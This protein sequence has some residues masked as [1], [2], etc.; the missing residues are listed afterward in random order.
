MATELAKAYVQIVP[1]AEGISGSIS[2]VLSGEATTAGAGAGQSIA[3]S[4]ASTL[5]PALTA[6]GIGAI[7][8]GTIDTVA[9]AINEVASAGDEI[10]K[11]SQKLGVNAEQYQALS[12]AAEHCGFSTSTYST[13]VK[14]LQQSGYEG[15]LVDYLDGLMAIE[16]PTERAAQAQEVLGEKTAN[17]MAAFLNGS[18][19]ISDYGSR[20][21]ELGGMMSNESVAASAAF[22][23]A[24]TDL[25]TAMKG[26]AVDVVGTFLPSC[27]EV[28]NGLAAVFAGDTGGAAMVKQG[29]DDMI[30]NIKASAPQMI[31]SA[32]TLV[33]SLLDCF[34]DNLPE[35]IEMGVTIVLKLA[36]GL[37]KAIPQLVSQLPQICTAIVNGIKN[38]LPEMAEVGGN[39]LSG[40]WNGI[41]DKIGW[42]KDKIFGLG[43]QIISAIK[44]VFGIASPSKVMRDQVGKFIAEGVG[45]GITENTDYVDDAMTDLLGA[46]EGTATAKINASVNGVGGSLASA[47]TGGTSMEQVVSLLSAYLPKIGTNLVLDN[48]AIVGQMMPAIDSQLG[49]RAAYAGRGL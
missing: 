41:S 48:G 13:A 28:V 45:V 6:L 35:I 34:I 49:Y 27:S 43:D 30:S 21:S 9:G 12:F 8:K 33:E 20:L 40:L 38:V 19:T 36:V 15:T 22:E 2:S 32:L 42:I 10:D 23:D 1:S 44:G 24:I 31:Q 29:L 11:S 3:S 26:V 46:T 18:E 39:I 4:L 37:I 5:G 14:K 47:M 16:D 17:E 7:I 25:Q